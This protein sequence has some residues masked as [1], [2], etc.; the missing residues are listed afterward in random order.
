MVWENHPS[1]NSKM[2]PLKSSFLLRR[3]LELIFFWC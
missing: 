2:I 1:E 3:K